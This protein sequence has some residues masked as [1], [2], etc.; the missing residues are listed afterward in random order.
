[1]PESGMGYYY[2]NKGDKIASTKRLIQKYN[3]NLCLFMELNFNRSKVNLSANLAS[4]FQ[5]K[6]RE[7]RC[8]TAPNIGK[9]T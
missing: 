8:V 5:Y 7:T 2:R 6:E 1:M 9:M 4:C 3:V